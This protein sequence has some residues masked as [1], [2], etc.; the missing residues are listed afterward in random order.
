MLLV[1]IVSPAQAA[2]IAPTGDGK[3]IAFYGVMVHKT[4]SYGTLIERQSG[5]A[6]LQTAGRAANWAYGKGVPPGYSPAMED[7]VVASARGKVTWITD[8]M[9]PRCTGANCVVVQLLLDRAGAF[10]KIAS[11]PYLASCWSVARGSVAGYTRIGVPSGYGLY[12]HFD[13]MKRVGRDE[14]VTSTYPFGVGRTATELDTIS[15]ATD[16]PIKGVVHVTSDSAQ[17]AVSY[18]FLDTWL[19]PARVEPHVTLCG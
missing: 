16:L 1:G 12:G 18:T 4:L 17:S 14:L 6:A 19:K 8:T 2:T 5:Y 9:T 10:F 15:I 13:P 3:T 7:V 11:G